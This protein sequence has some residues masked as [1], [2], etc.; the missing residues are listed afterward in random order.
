M[1]MTITVIRG[2]EILGLGDYYVEHF[3][4]IKYYS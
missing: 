4:L 1:K 2:C 3:F